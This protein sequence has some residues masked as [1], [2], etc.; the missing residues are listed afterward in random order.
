[1][2]R[3]KFQVSKLAYPVSQGGARERAAS[4]EPI[5]VEEELSHSKDY[6]RV[7]LPHRLKA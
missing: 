2:T 6:V 3:W 7:W 4:G 1:M 5:E